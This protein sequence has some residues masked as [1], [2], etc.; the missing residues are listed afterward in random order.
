ME[1]GVRKTATK[2]S[3]SSANNANRTT[4]IIGGTKLSQ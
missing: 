1:R 4:K 2:I 3:L